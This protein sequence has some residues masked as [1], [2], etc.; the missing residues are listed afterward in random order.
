VLLPHT[1]GHNSIATHENGSSASIRGATARPQSPVGNR[2]AFAPAKKTIMKKW[3]CAVPFVVAAW[4]LMAA[5]PARAGSG[6][7]ALHG[8]LLITGSNTM[9]PL[10]SAI[11]RR[12]EALHP[13][14]VIEVQPGGSGRGLDDT[15]GS[16]ADIGM[17][18]RGLGDGEHD[19]TGLPIARD[20]V[21]L[22]VHKDNPVKALTDAQVIAIF[23]GSLTNWKQVGGPDAPI[24]PYQAEGWRTSSELFASYFKLE[25]RAIKALPAYG[26]TASRLRLL[27]QDRHAI[28]YTSVGLAERS[29]QS[30]APIRLLPVGGTAA[31]SRTIRSGHF[32]I[33][34]PLT[35]VTRP[36]PSPLAKAFMEYCGTAHI[37]DLVV[38]HDFVPYLD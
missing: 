17:V 37:R 15:R 31:S 19:I 34:R 10:V 7:D 6:S 16:R 32:P 30:G 4:M 23:T 18:S 14:V 9:A 20:G 8:H 27:A 3:T 33:S 38:A 12:F 22:A 28:L 1:I 11:A 21:A 25:R 26:D 5:C 35:L 29:A 13:G 36:R 2:A 24:A